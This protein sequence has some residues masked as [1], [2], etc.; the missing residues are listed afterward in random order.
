MK[1]KESVLTKMRKG[2]TFIEYAL[3]AA[4]VA[5]AVAAAALLFGDKLKGLFTETGNQAGTVAEDVKN[6][7]LHINGGEKPTPTP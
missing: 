1:T 5:I 4:L 6:V 3:L 7:K 2:A